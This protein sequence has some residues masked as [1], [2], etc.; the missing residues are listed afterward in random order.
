MGGRALGVAMSHADIDGGTI[1][2]AVIGGTTAVAG[3]FS[4]MTCTT[5]VVGGNTLSGT[6]LGFVDGVTAG[7][8]AAS[9]AVVLDASKGINTITSATITTLTSTT[10]NATNVDAGASGTAGS[11]DVFPATA[12]KGKLAITSADSAGDTTTTIVN[13]SQAAAR[14]Y[15]IPDAGASA[16]FLMT[17]GAQTKNA[18][19]T[20][21]TGADLIFSGTTGQN[22]ITVTDNLADALSVKITGGNDFF[23]LDS[24]DNAEKMNVTTRLTTTDGVSSGTARVVGG[25]AYTNTAA[26][27]AVTNTTTETL[28]DTKYSIPANTLKAGTLV[29]VRFQGIATATNATDTLAIALKIGSTDAA[30]PVGGTTLISMTATDVTNNDVFTGEFEL[31]CRTA[32]A[33]GTMVGVG[34]YKSIPAAEGTMT[35]KDDILASTAVDTTAAQL[36]AV[37]ATWSVANAGNSCRLDFVLVEII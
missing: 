33:G 13:A 9:K 5:A 37:S 7:T 23:V 17:E 20:L 12:A 30:P 28:F 34:T 21:A 15:T 24:T 25:V 26:S 29:R 4:T 22:E 27:T 1:D 16:S 8:A 6:E 18:N 11:V 14:T 36:L 2:N 32:G 35:I 10:V 31:I 3:T 19:L